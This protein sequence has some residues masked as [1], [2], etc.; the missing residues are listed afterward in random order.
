MAHYAAEKALVLKT[1]GYEDDGPE[2]VMAFTV[3]SVSEIVKCLMGKRELDA[4]LGMPR[5]TRFG[6]KAEAP[7]HD[8]K[9]DRFWTLPIAKPGTVAQ[10]NW[11]SLPKYAILEERSHVMATMNVSLP[12]QMKEWV[13][14]Q[15]E[16]GK[17][18]NSSDYVRDLIRKDQERTTKILALQRLLDEGL[19]SG[20]AE[21]FE[22]EAFLARMRAKHGE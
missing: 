16:S 19:A 4:S 5:R 13:E 2:Y 15:T 11:Q 18:S 10:S 12:D 6:I 20:A 3:G 21:D 1:I 22:P 17:Y 14:A 7:S 8:R 9:C